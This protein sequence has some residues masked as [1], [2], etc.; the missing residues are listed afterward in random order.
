MEK[1]ITVLLLFTLAKMLGLYLEVTA[2]NDH[3]SSK[4]VLCIYCYYLLNKKILKD[5]SL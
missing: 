3:F 5:D 4:I 1:Y 2:L